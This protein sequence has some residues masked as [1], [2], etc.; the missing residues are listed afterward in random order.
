MK[1]DSVIYLSDWFGEV[2]QFLIFF[3][4]TESLFGDG[5]D[6]FGE[7]EDLGRRIFKEGSFWCGPDL[8]GGLR[9]TV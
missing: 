3:F 8:D 1:S 6:G 5:V 4:R 2:T 9:A 7:R